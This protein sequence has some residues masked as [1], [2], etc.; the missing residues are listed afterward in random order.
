MKTPVPILKLERLVNVAVP[1]KRKGC[2]AHRQLSRELFRAAPVLR[3]FLK[4]FAMENS[5]QP[6][7][8]G[9]SPRL[10]K[11]VFSPPGN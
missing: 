1:E 10:L 2:G 9:S 8:S 7:G 4:S 5:A 11:Y 6:A 3:V